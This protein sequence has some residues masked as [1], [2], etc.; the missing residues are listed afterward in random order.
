LFLKEEPTGQRADIARKELAQVQAI[1]Q[2]S[3]VRAQ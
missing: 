2:R 1:V 3:A